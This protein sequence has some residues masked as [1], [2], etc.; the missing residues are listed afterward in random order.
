MSPRAR[1]ESSVIRFLRF[2]R[3]GDAACT[4]TRKHR[5]EFAARG[6]RVAISAQRLAELAAADL[7]LREGDRV[8]LTPAGRAHL[9]RLLADDDPF[10]RQH[11]GIRR[12][13]QSH[14]DPVGAILIDEAESPLSWLAKRRGPGGRPLIDAAQFQA[15]ERLR[16]DFTRAGLTPRV[17]SNWIA[18]VAQG[19]RA[20][21]ASAAS[22]SDAVLAAKERVSRAL[23]AAGPEF[24]GLLLDVCCFLK[25]LE[26][27]ERE[28]HWPPR[29]A[30]VVLGLALDRLARHYGIRSELRGPSRSA[31]RAWQAPGARPTING[32]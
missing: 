31:M 11:E 5:L 20:T 30:K 23:E 19:R 15:G 32:Q 25:G 12:R 8:A 4:E 2:L 1:K 7:V 18:P 28:R 3:A 21:G 29:T 26:T 14:R 9:A 17:T 13:E 24:C 6:G 27:V 10:L 16:A 22:F